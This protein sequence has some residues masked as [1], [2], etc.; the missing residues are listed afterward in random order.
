MTGLERRPGHALAADMAG[1]KDEP[2][3]DWH[4]SAG[5]RGDHG[6]VADA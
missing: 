4:D 1:A 3:L 6:L 2:S 5:R